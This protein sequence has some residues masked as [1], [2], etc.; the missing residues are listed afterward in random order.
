MIPGESRHP[1]EGTHFGRLYSFPVR[2]GLCQ[3]CPWSPILFRIFMDRISRAN[4]PNQLNQFTQQVKL[5]S[6][7]I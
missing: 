6:H 3:G 5:I 2:V 4:N 7:Q 1:A